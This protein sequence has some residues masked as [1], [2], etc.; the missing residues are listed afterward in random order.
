VNLAGGAPS[1]SAIAI[2]QYANPVDTSPA[3]YSPLSLTNLSVTLGG[4]NVL[5]SSLSYTYENF[6]SQIMT[7]E[8][9]TSSDIGVACGLIPQ[10]WWEMNRVYYIDLARSREADKAMPRNLNVSFNNNS[11]I[12]MDVMIFTIYLDKI[13]IDIETGLVRK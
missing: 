13:E 1:G 11:L 12:P 7:A 9:L 6:L 5:N 10:S 2:A 8:T 3:T 4:V